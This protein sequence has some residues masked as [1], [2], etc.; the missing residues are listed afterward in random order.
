MPRRP[1]RRSTA[2]GEH[3]PVLLAE[4]LD[5]LRPQP[6]EMV[7]DCTLGFAGHAKAL[8]ERVGP[9]GLLVGMDW[10]EENLSRARPILETTGLPFRLHHANFAG[11]P[12]V[13]GME[14]L[15]QVDAI[16]ADVGV[17]SMQIDDP[18]RG[19]SYVREGPLDMRMDR[20]R[21]RSATDLLAQLS[22]RDLADTLRT[23]GDEPHAAAIAHAIVQARAREPITTTSQLSAIV[24]MAVGKPVTRAAGW[25]LHK[26]KKQW[27]LHPAARTFQALRIMVNRELA[28]LQE[29]LRVLPYC[30][31]PGGRAAIIS[32]H[33]GED[34]LVKTAFKSGLQ[35]KVYA[36]S[37]EE[38]VRASYEER[39]MNPRSRS[40][41]L[42]W[43]LRLAS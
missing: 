17:S 38:P 9:T 28:N 31:K 36:A 29:L 27:E 25:R 10:D 8:L 20:S 3:R 42:R 33:S 15:T 41:K 43:A 37:S 16:L 5:A 24:G 7:V 23:F 14:G 11:L 4:V 35:Q 2:P 40:A 34:R 1:L 26:S 19:F 22:E 21:G 39:G 6:G 18:T 13:L 12:Q 30:L 32:F